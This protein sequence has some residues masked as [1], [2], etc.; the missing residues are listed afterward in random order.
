[1]YTDKWHLSMEPDPKTGTWKYNFTY[2]YPPIT[3]RQDCTNPFVHA[4]PRFKNGKF[5][6][7]AMHNGE[8]AYF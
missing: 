7:N 5:K 8:K 1:M 4:N 3:T 2:A 6:K